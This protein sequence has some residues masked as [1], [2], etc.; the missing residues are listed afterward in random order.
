M[1]NDYIDVYTADPVTSAQTSLSDNQLTT[2]L[3]TASTIKMTKHKNFTGGKGSNAHLISV[4]FNTVW[5]W[6][7]C[8]HIFSKTVADDIIADNTILVRHIRYIFFH[9]HTALLVP[10]Q[11][12]I[13]YW[14][15]FNYIVKWFSRWCASVLN[16]LPFF[17]L[18]YFIPPLGH[19]LVTHARCPSPA[20]C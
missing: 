13:S 4:P 19:I 12:Q 1:N 10:K 17:L 5:G 7:P 14:R 3:N 6:E 18:L 11:C 16:T 9:H 15:Y 8:D 2:V 20:Q